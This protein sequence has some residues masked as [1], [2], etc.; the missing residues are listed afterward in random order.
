MVHQQFHGG[1]MWS[2]SRL[3]IREHGYRVM[4]RGILATGIREGF[5]V[6]GMLGIVPILHQHLIQKHKIHPTAAGLYASIIGGL[7][8]S[9]AS[10]PFDLIK[11]SMQVDL[12]GLRYRSFLQT[13]RCLYKEGGIVR[14]YAGALWRALN[15]IG[16]I[17][18]ANECRIHLPDL[19]FR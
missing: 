1:S 15:I 16:T 13:A 2:A 7:G 11:T 19:L 8:A 10:Q 4:T 5:Y 18:I 14:F 6:S 12:Q 9:I 17:Y 3:L